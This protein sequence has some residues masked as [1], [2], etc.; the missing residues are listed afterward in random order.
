MKSISA[1]AGRKIKEAY[2]ARK[3]KTG[4]RYKVYATE[5]RWFLIQNCQILCIFLSFTFC[6]LA[7]TSTRLFEQ[8]TPAAFHIAEFPCR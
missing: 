3:Q 8:L 1:K 7:P 4:Y 6:E 5:A 2:R